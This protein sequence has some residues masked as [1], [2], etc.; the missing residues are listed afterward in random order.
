MYQTRTGASP[1]DAQKEKRHLLNLIL[2][3][4]TSNKRD[5]SQLVENFH[6]F[7][8]GKTHGTLMEKTHGNA[9]SMGFF[10]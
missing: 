2:L 9:F 8:H 5:F 1:V 10:P 7:F 4:S 6:G 3:L